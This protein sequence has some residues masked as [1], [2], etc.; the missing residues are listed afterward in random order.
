MGKMGQDGRLPMELGGIL[1]RFLRGEVRIGNEFLDGT[2]LVRQSRVVSQV[3][4]PHSSAA[5]HLD[6][7]ISVLKYNAFL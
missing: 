5:Q 4:L 7:T 3:D 6:D 1:G 2:R